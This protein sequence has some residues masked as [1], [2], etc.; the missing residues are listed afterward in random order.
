MIPAVMALAA[1][2]LGDAL[3]LMWVH[4]T[5]S[6]IACPIGSCDVV[7]ASAYAEVW[8][9]PVAGI[10]VAGYLALLAL[11]TMAWRAED[12]AGRRGWLRWVFAGGLAGVLYAIYLTY[13][14]L[15]VINAIC[16][17]CVVSAIVITL[18]CIISGLALRRPALPSS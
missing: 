17:W 18:I 6:K 3:Y 12:E 2:G 16:F 10:G 14:E 5:A 11:G 4:A 8:G 15:Y 1:L 13:L 9:F 7:N